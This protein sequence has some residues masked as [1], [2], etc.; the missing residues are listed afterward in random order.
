ME[1]NDNQIISIS[2]DNADN[3]ERGVLVAIDG[4]SRATSGTIVNNF[5]SGY[6]V[7]ITWSVNSQNASSNTSNITVK[8]QL[9]STGSS[10]SINSS[11]TKNG[12]LT[13]NGTKYTFTFNAGISGNQT[14]TVYTKTVD[15]AH[16]SDGTKTVALATTLGIA[17]T[18]SGTYYGNVSASG[19]AG[20]NTIPRASSFSLS[21]SSIDAGKTITVN[22]SRASDSFTH[23]VFYSFGGNRA[24][25]ST[26]ATTSASYAIPIAH[27]NAIPNATSGTATISVDTYNGGTLIGSASKNFTITAPASVKPT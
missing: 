6:R 5:R 17:V 20:L 3:L 12:S 18:L 24:T 22:I 26:N 4:Q 21:S 23:K 15:V 11:A 10:Y 13:I 14:K 19:N 25:I 8:A 16:N 7:Q 2:E 27:L 1:N 9:V